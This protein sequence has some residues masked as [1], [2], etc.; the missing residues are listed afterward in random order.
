MTGLPHPLTEPPFAEGPKGADPG[1]GGEPIPHLVSTAPFD[2][3]SVEQLTPEQERF[4]LASQWTMMWWRF[5]QHRLA[6]FAGG[7]LLLLYLSI[8]ASESLE[9]SALPTRHMDSIFAPPQQLHFFDDQGN[10][11]GPFVYGY[12]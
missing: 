2:P 6:V 8:F 12:S 9:P 11:V 10:F 7:F 3:R 1:G 5:R 4:Y